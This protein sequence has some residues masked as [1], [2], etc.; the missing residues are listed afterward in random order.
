MI[1]IIMIGVAGYLTVQRFQ[2]VTRSACARMSDS[3]GL[4]PGSAVTRMG[5][6]VGT[7]DSISQEFTNVK[8]T[9]SLD[10][11]TEIPDG[12]SA[13][14]RSR[15]VLAD[16]SLELIGGRSGSLLGDGGCIPIS[17]TATPKSVS[18]LS[19]ATMKVMSSIEGSAGVSGI[20]DLVATIADQLPDQ[21]QRIND[22]LTAAAGL[23]PHLDAMLA[24]V[25]STLRNLDTVA[26]QSVQAWPQI[27]MSLRTAP[28]VLRTLSSSVFPS[29]ESM[30]NELPDTITMVADIQLRVGPRLWPALDKVALA[31]KLL[32][33]QSGTIRQLAD[34]IPVMTTSFLRL[35][36]SHDGQVHVN[37]PNFRTTA[38]V[39]ACLVERLRCQSAAGALRYS[40]VDLLQLVFKGLSR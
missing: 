1:V 28:A 32:A 40:D 39:H 24:D 11:S 17:R 22:T 13:A 15:G 27:A 38:P 29:V 25:V 30:F 20:G 12:V 23:A 10:A 2:H 5:V 19:E 36:G 8:V 3:I 18:Q 7:V 33:T 21:S 31:V 4:Y 37:A 34:L 35:V 16:R 26:E 14:T 9:F 6:P